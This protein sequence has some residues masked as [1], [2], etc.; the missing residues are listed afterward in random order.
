MSYFTVR[1]TVTAVAA[2]L[3]IYAQAMDLSFNSGTSVD[4]GD[5]KIGHTTGLGLG[6]DGKTLSLGGMSATE[7]DVGSQK[8]NHGTAIGIKNLPMSVFKVPGL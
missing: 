3:P 8:L 5:V 7:I 1:A 2:I 4:L 6:T